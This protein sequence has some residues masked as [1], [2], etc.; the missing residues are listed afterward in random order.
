MKIVLQDRV[1][2]PSLTQMAHEW[3]M[4]LKSTDGTGRAGHTWIFDALKEAKSL[5]ET[6]F[7]PRDEMSNEEI[8][9]RSRR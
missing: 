4:N 6:Y 1:V 5:P 8:W 9:H 3:D 7:L 2:N